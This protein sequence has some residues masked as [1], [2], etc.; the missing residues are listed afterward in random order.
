MIQPLSRRAFGA[1]LGAAALAAA[2]PK[3]A[4]AQSPLKLKM[5]LNWR[6]QGPQCWFFLAQDN[7]YLKEAGLDVTMDQGNGSGAAVGS[8]ASGSYDLGFGDINA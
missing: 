4:L 1:T 8:V 7:G 6:Y 5:V 3:P 2:I